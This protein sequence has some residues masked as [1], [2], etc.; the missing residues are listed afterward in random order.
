[1]KPMTLSKFV[2]ITGTQSCLYALDEHGVVWKHREQSRTACGGN[3][4]KHTCEYQTI[5]WWEALDQQCGYPGWP[6]TEKELAE[7]EVEALLQ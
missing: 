2:Q 4:Y 3:H 5:S 6:P 7:R 1:M